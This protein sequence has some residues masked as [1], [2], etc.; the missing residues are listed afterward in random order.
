MSDQKWNLRQLL[1]SAFVYV[2]SYEA[3]QSTAA[4]T[5]DQLLDEQ[6]Q[7]LKPAAK[8][9]IVDASGK[10][11]GSRISRYDRL[12]GLKDGMKAV[13]DAVKA[14]KQDEE[15]LKNLGIYEVDPAFQDQQQVQELLGSADEE[16]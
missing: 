16:S 5:L 12:T 10:D 15:V 6:I 3:N 9:T 13:V 4:I 11:V 2:R 8:R 14:A 7:F 1:H